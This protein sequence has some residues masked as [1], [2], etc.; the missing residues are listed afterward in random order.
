MSRLNELLSRM[1]KILTHCLKA[2]VNLLS[3]SQQLLADAF[4]RSCKLNALWLD[5]PEP[6]QGRQRAQARRDC[7]MRIFALLHNGLSISRCQWKLNRSDP[8][9]TKASVDEVRREERAEGSELFD[10]SDVLESMLQIAEQRLPSG[11]SVACSHS[12]GT[13]QEHAPRGRVRSRNSGM[14]KIQIF[15]LSS[16]GGL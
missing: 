15:G 11:W 6:R 4:P 5:A 8:I 12:G 3:L 10:R 1:P 13:L 7:R 9:N 14:L 16:G 2:S